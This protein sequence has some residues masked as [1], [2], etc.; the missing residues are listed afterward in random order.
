MIIFTPL[1]GRYFFAGVKN[2]EKTGEIP[3]TAI[4]G[5]GC[6]RFLGFRQQIAGVLEAQML[7]IF[8]M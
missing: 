5:D 6:N 1:I 8:E 3:E 4:K 2:P 7:D